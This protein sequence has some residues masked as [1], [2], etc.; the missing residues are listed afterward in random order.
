MKGSKYRKILSRE[1]RRKWLVAGA[2]D[3]PKIRLEHAA[4]ARLPREDK[5]LHCYSTSAMTCFFFCCC[6]LFKSS[7]V[8][9]FELFRFLRTAIPTR[10]GQYTRSV[11]LTAL[12]VKLQATPPVHKVGKEASEHPVQS[13][14]SSLTFLSVFGVVVGVT[15]QTRRNQFKHSSFLFSF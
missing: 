12:L 10:V 9:L 2:I 11:E 6:S 3:E 5:L 14:I 15:R 7:T 4:T 13:M 1:K 8:T